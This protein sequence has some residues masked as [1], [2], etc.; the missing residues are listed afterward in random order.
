[1]K[2]EIDQKIIDKTECDKGFTCMGGTP[3]YCS[4]ISTLGYN[5]LKLECQDNLDCGHKRTYGGLHACN[6]PVRHAIFTK[7]GK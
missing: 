6:C 5:L 2:I 7:Y 1:M 4:V 3:L